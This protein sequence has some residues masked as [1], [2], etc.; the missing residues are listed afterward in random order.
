M[1]APV[2][3]ETAAQHVVR[4]LQGSSYFECGRVRGHGGCA[5]AGKK[6]REWFDHMTS[7]GQITVL[8][9]RSALPQY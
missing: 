4:V 2:D 9:G 6:T 5:A 8:G 7:K 3:M 1:S